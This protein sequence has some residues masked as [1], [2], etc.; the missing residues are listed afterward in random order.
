LHRYNVLL[1]E[2]KVDHQ[3]ALTANQRLPQIV[4]AIEEE[5]RLEAQQAA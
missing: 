5:E 3:Y 2:A 4:A 1:G